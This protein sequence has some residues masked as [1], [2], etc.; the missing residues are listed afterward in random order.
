M[1]SAKIFIDTD[2]EITFVLEKIL[3]A[4]NE[5]VCL[6][7]PDRASLFTSISGLKLIKRVIDKSNKLLV[8]VT[9]DQNGSDLASQADLIVVSRVGEISNDLWEK[10]QKSKFEFVKK[11]KNRVYYQPE[12]LIQEEPEIA[13]QPETIS[14]KDLI[15][16]SPESIEEENA[17][18]EPEITNDEYEKIEESPKSDEVEFNEIPQVK[19]R[20]DDE[21]IRDAQENIENQVESVKEYKNLENSIENGKNDTVRMRRK[22]SENLESLDF[23]FGKDIN[24]QKKK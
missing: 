11:H 9:L 10:A 23:T 6:I 16:S 19:I 3:S 21:E 20:V 22:S 17:D 15:A 18:I 5:R 7:I 1:D 2:N 13:S 8:I 12:N 14:I 24:P 4:K